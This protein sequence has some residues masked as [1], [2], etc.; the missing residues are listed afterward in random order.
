MLW[1]PSANDCARP[2]RILKIERGSSV[3]APHVTLS[4]GGAVTVPMKEDGL[5]ALIG[6]AD[7]NL[8]EAKAKGRNKSM[9]REQA[10]P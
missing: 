6:I 1:M 3:A 9:V 2:Y 8:Y 4:V 7:R 5:H 10:S